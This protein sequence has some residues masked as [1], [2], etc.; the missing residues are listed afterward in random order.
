MSE[1]QH[2]HGRA[3]QQSGERGGGAAADKG[4]PGQ[5]KLAEWVSLG[6][7]GALIV[8]LA[9]FLVYE[10]VKGDS[11]FNL[12]RTVPQMDAVQ[13]V[14]GTFILPVEVENPG[15]R[16]LRDLSVELTYTPPGAQEPQ[17]AEA[18]IDYLGEGARQRVYFYL[19]HDPRQ[20]PVQVRPVHYQ[21]D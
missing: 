20:V 2:Q 1:D 6:I 3:K 12:A 10:I 17:K 11:K 13:Q 14:S 16:T 8:A 9:A 5:R 21:L 15:E 4:R 7:S 19:D 18:K